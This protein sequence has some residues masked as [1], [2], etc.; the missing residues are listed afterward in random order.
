[1]AEEVLFRNRR[2]ERPAT[3]DEYRQNGG[4]QAL[5]EAVRRRSPEEVQ[6]LVL[7]SGLRGRGAAD[8]H[9]Q[10][11]LVARRGA[12][13]DHPALLS[14]PESLYLKCLILAVE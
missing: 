10:A 11:R 2:P 3:I 12:A 7:A 8:P 1:M 4:Y 14:L 9:R 13:Q 5:A 6:Q